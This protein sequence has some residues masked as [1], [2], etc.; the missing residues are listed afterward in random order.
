MA[1][2]NAGALPAYQDIPAYLREGHEEVLPNRR[3]DA[4]DRVLET[5]QSF[6]GD[7]AKAKVVD[8]SWRELPVQKRLEHALVHGITDWIEAEGE[9]A[10]LAADRQLSVLER[11]LMDGMKVVGALFRA[12]Q[13]LLLADVLAASGGK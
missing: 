6:K 3:P 4:T 7:G 8:L 10:R 1:I 13:V 12:G 2:V 9:E 5:A 11:P